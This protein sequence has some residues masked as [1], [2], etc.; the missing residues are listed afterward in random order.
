VLAPA[1]IVTVIE[2][3]DVA[4][5]AS[6]NAIRPNSLSA[7]FCVSW[8]IGAPNV[9][10]PVFDAIVRSM[11]V[12]VDRPKTRTYSLRFEPGV[13]ALVVTV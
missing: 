12:I 2:P 3:G 4:T 9:N 13:N 11:P 8:K 1:S 5:V 10:P 7:E 6:N